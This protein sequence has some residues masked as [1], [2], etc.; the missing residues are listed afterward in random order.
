MLAAAGC[1]DFSWCDE[2]SRWK[3]SEVHRIVEL[4]LR[5]TLNRKSVPKDLS[6]YLK[7]IDRFMREKSFVVID[8]ERRLKDDDLGIQGRLD[9]SGLICGARALIDFKTGVCS[10]AVGLQLALYGHMLALGAWWARDAVQL[11]ADGTYSM[12]IFPIMDWPKD[13]STAL[14][15]VRVAKWKQQVGLL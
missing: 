11:K 10:P 9:A 3:G 15:A 7:A 12:K 2:E 14:S 6:G 8:V 5:G 13:L 4:R 1:T